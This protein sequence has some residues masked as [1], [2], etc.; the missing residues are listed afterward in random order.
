M[1]FITDCKY[2][3]I[4]FTKYSF[5]TTHSASPYFNL[6]FF[7]FHHFPYM[8]PTTDLLATWF[9]DFNARYFRGELPRPHLRLSKARTRLG[10]FSCRGKRQLLR[11]VYTDFTISLSIYYD[12]EEK[13]Y[14]TVLLHEMIHYYICYKGI[15]DTSP[16]GE[17]FQ[18]M[19]LAINA[20]GWHISVS[21]NTKG[22]KV[23]GIDHRPA[24]CHLLL[25]VRTQG[26]ELFFAPV[27]PN[28]LEA[29]E[30]KIL[31]IPR[32]IA[33]HEWYLSHDR[34]F[35]GHHRV[36]SLRGWRITEAQLEEYRKVMKVLQLK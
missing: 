27:D 25:A 21:Q 20:R 23:R 17:M 22:W 13:E 28:Y 33:W 1:C 19:M 14:Q 3:E 12:C 18:R 26:G 2:G 24:T 35:D 29:L 10:S 7:P 4:L 6:Q 9:D 11:T 16:H 32:Q 31:S 5:D 30:Q 8:L 15:R 34:Q 36:R